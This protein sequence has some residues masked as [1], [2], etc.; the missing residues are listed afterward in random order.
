MNPVY[1][2][3]GAALLAVAAAMAGLA[4]CGH[5]APPPGSAAPAPSASHHITT[6]PATPLPSGRPSAATP[7]DKVISSRVSYP[8]H[9][10]NDAGNPG[11]VAHSAKVPPVPKLVA[12]SAGDHPG[13]PGE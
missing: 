10:P 4:A 9:W 3:R 11:S 5:T 2:A 6:G 8:W 12:I 1:K 7:A 13:G